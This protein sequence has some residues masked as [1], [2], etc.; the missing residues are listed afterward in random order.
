MCAYSRMRFSAGALKWC[1]DCGSSIFGERVH[2]PEDLPR[3][4]LFVGEDGVVAS[5]QLRAAPWARRRDQTGGV[6]AASVVGVAPQADVLVADHSRQLFV[7]PDD[8]L[9]ALPAQRLS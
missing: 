3:W 1:V 7:L 9:A 4:T 5:G 6:E 8:G 2:A